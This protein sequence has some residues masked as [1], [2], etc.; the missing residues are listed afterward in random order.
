MTEELPRKDEDAMFDN[1]ARYRAIFENSPIALLEEDFSG[2]KKYINEKKS[3]GVKNL[4]AFFAKHPEEL[5]KCADLVKI[6]DVNNAAIVLLGASNKKK[7]LRGISQWYV[8]ES[9]L[10]FME[11]IIAISEG[12]TSFEAEGINMRLDGEIIY[13]LLKWNIIPGCELDLCRTLVSLTDISE[14]NR[15]WDALRSSEEKYRTIFETA[16][17]FIVSISREGLIVDSN[18]RVREFL[19]YSP[20]E[21]I[22]QS[23]VKI[24]HQDY[25]DKAQKSL[26]EIMNKGSLSNEEYRMVH[27]DGTIIDVNINSSALKNKAGKYDRCL[28]LVEDITRRKK[29]QDSL[30]WELAVNTSMAKLLKPLLSSSSNIS[31]MTSNILAQAK[32]ITGSEHGYV[33]MIDPETGDNLGHA[34]TE[35]MKKGMCQIS[36][37][38]SLPRFPKGPDGLYS[39]LWGYALNTRIP[40]FTNSPSSHIS[41]RGTPKGHIVLTRFLSVPVMIG[42]ELVGQIALANSHRDYT[43]RDLEA[44]I[45]MGELYALALRRLRMESA[46]QESEDKYR[47]LVESS[48]DGVVIQQEGKVAYINPAGAKILGVKKPFELLRKEIPAFLHPDYLALLEESARTLTKVSQ[49]ILEREMTRMD[50][51]TIYIEVTALPFTYKGKPAVQAIF[52]D[53]TERKRMEGELTRSRAKY[54]QLVELAYD[55]IGVCDTEYNITF[56]NQRLAEMLGYQISE[57]MGRSIFDLLDKDGKKA[58]RSYVERRKQGL[59]E[60]HDL[61]FIRKDGTRMY[62]LVNAS[63]LTDDQGHFSGILLIIADISDRKKMEEDLRNENEKLELITK[64]MGVGVAIILQDRKVVWANSVLKDLYGSTEGKYCY[65]AMHQLDNACVDCGIVKVFRGKSMHT[66]EQASTNIK[67]EKVWSQIITTP[68]KNSKGDVILALEI[69]IPITNRKKMEEELRESEEKYREIVESAN[70]IIFKW[71]LK[72]NVLSFNEFAERFFGF[73]RDEVIGKNLYETIVPKTESSGRDISN[74]IQLIISDEKNSDNINEN[75]KKNGERVWV[76][77]TNKP[78]RNKDGEVIAVLSVGTDITDQMKDEERLRLA[79]Q[80]LQDIIDFLPD[81]TLVMDKE[82]VI[83]AWNKAIEEMT[84]V[85]KEAMIG[86]GNYEYSLPFYGSRRPG[87][88]DLV[89]HPNQGIEKMYKTIQKEGNTIYAEVFVK[90]RGVEKHLWATASQLFDSDGDVVGAIESIRDITERKR[91]EEALLASEEKYRSLYENIPDGIYQSTEAGKLI[92]VNQA[93]VDI[94]GYGSKEELL[95]VNM[96]NDLYANPGERRSTI[97]KLN[98]DGEIR[99]SDLVLKRKDGK[100]IHV[101]ENAH[102]VKDHSGKILYYEGTITDITERKRMEDALKHFSEHLADLVDD[103]AAQLQVSEERFRRIIEAS[104]DAMMVVDDDG[105]IAE[106]NQAALGLLKLEGK[107]LLIGRNYLDFIITRDKPLAVGSMTHT[108]VSGFMKDLEFS[109]L[110]KYGEEIPVSISAGLIQESSSKLGSVVLIIKDITQRKMAEAELKRVMEMREQFISNITHELRTPLVAMMGYLDYILSGKMGQVPEKIGENLTVVKRNTDRLITLTNDILD[111]RRIEAG[112]IRLEIE[113][114]D[115]REI[116][117]CCRNELEPFLIEKQQ[118]FELI[119]EEAPL[120]IDGDKV[121]IAQI[122]TNLLGNASKF[123]PEHGKISVETHDDV[124]T[125]RIIVSD[126][127]IGIRSE[128]LERVFEPFTAIKKPS[129]VRGTGL[130]LSVTKGLVEAHGGKIW[131]ESAGEGQGARFIFVLPKEVVIAG[132][133]GSV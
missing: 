39:S 80:Q 113:K 86:K 91:I 65:S 118:V 120:I 64:N 48:T 33:T 42:D 56:I 46:L 2:V 20:E 70:S 35:M 125:A 73:S 30:I 126:T 112:K 52:R 123:T 6:L 31:I 104:P 69:V 121:K 41:S 122:L 103:R 117:K 7:A 50:G 72:G 115:L 57:L 67:G 97:E 132:G 133:S 88:I 63:P 79:H 13:T 111:I 49:P 5:I 16:A 107:E 21:I 53:I 23:M 96:E 14:R 26:K 25:I 81:A 62:A 29:A 74:L 17:N 9:Y 55:G 37:D 76:H 66:L 68:I 92:T 130:G 28:C 82:G 75:V 40:F 83:I 99:T 15:M 27:K 89:M 19:G 61:E 131:A 11:E 32:F 127:G 10:R 77:W 1:E 128:D 22:G 119:G 8:K 38:G 3:S 85:Q 59:S 43:E 94:L 116:I 95:N 93:L 114:V 34:Q 58:G 124:T 109:V 101:L 51:K 108:Y 12:K 45:R 100:R 60:Q 4:R 84:G 90:L 47:R 110:T 102:L 98:Q 44:I 87:L 71:D 54:Q 18:S 106:C 36:K 129:Y 78:L 24:F 105:T